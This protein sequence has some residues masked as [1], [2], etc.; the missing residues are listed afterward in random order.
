MFCATPSLIILHIFRIILYK[1]WRYTTEVICYYFRIYYFSFNTDYSCS[2]NRK[3]EMSN[4]N[5]KRSIKYLFDTQLM[6]MQAYST[7]SVCSIKN[8]EIYHY[9]KLKNATINCT[10]LK[11]WITIEINVAECRHKSRMLLEITGAKF[12]AI[13]CKSVKETQFNSYD[14]FYNRYI[15]KI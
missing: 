8:L 13:V 4:K 12:A 10:R 1:S 7:Y 15:H 9:F 5:T 2:F 3:T 6:Y 11:T 14:D